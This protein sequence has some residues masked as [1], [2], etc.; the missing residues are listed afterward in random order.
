VQAQTGINVIQYSKDSFHEEV[1]SN[2]GA[3]D[4]FLSDPNKNVWIDIDGTHCDLTNAHLS[5][6]LKLH[7]VVREELGS[8]EHRPKMEDF[9]DHI[10]LVLNML[11]FDHK[12]RKIGREQI[13]FLLGPS[14]LISFQETGKDGD[15]FN[16]IRHRM[17]NAKGRHRKL[18]VDYL[19]ISLIDTIVDH[20][21]EIL[22]NIGDHIEM[23]ES[24]ILA[25]PSYEKLHEI[26]GLKR[27]LIL[28]RKSVW[29]LREVL[30]KLEN[31]NHELVQE[32]TYPYI[33][34]AYEHTIQVI[35][36]LESDRDIMAGLLDIYLTSLSNKMNSIMKVLTIISTIFMPLTFIVGLYGMNFKNMPE[37]EWHYG[38]YT[39]LGLCSAIVIGMIIFFKNKKWL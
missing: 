24:N 14:Y 12:T 10:Y 31:E 33:R 5:E 17:K 32:Y 27:E 29:P 26:Y 4:P 19:L 34:V 23:M 25:N 9:D 30:N 11:H 20:Y 39:V 1:V 8:I 3:L 28:L 37:I 18:G 35:E 13:T 36:T 22:E 16:N 38:Y 2:P 7:H 6:F 21:F 15:V